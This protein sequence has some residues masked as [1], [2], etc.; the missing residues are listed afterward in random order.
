MH[1]LCEC[2][3]NESIVM[4]DDSFQY[5]VVRR[6]LCFSWH[7][8][9]PNLLYPSFTVMCMDRSVERL[10]VEFRVTDDPI[11]NYDFHR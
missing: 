6:Y 9:S 5:E 7:C 2:V 4:P 10:S 3:S 11:S 1:L 8:I